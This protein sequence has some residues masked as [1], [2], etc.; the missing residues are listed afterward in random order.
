MQ[1]PAP[2]VRPQD[3]GLEEEEDAEEGEVRDTFLVSAAHAAWS[4]VACDA[5][6]LVGWWVGGLLCG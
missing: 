4:W 5:C 3:L 1:L 2:L 6:E